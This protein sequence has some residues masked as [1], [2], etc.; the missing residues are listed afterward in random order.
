MFDHLPEGSRTFFPCLAKDELPYIISQMDIVLAPSRK[1]T[2][3]HMRSDEILMY[4]G[5]KKIPWA[6]S[7]IPAALNWERGGL[8]CSTL[9]EWHSG[10]RHLIL[11]RDLRHS[12]GNEGFHIAARREM[13][14][15][16]QQWYKAFALV[17]PSPVKT[18]PETADVMA[19]EERA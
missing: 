16:I 1:T 19:G 7:P 5:I 15:H 10:L 2:L 4:S 18:V 12:L 8:I 3:N 6:A 17:Q 9:E 14:V 13:L 11:D